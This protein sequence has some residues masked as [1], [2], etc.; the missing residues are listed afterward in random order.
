MTARSGADSDRGVHLHASKPRRADEQGAGVPA[1]AR[2]GE[3]GDGVREAADD[4]DA[5]AGGAGARHGRDHL[6][7]RRRVRDGRHG[8]VGAVAGPRAVG[9][10]ENAVAAAAAAHRRARRQRERRRRG[11][12]GH[13]EERDEEKGGARFHCVF[14]ASAPL[15]GARVCFLDTEEA[16]LGSASCRMLALP[17]KRRLVGLVGWKA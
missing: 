6:A 17:A 14:Y 10:G 4:L 12:A 2:A 1:A 9:V 11:V 7:L 5:G 3:L 13:Q 16:A 15:L 8:A